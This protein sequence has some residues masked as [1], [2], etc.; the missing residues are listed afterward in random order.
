MKYTIY[1]FSLFLIT[2]SGCEK[3]KSPIKSEIPKNDTS[4]KIVFIMVD[5]VGWG[6]QI[7]RMNIDGSEL[8]QLTFSDEIIDSV[9]ERGYSMSYNPSWSAD[10]TKILY[11]R[12]LGTDTEQAVMMNE[13]GT[14]KHIVTYGSGYTA[15][16][17]WSPADNSFIVG[18]DLDCS[19]S[20]IIFVDTLGNR[21]NIPR[22]ENP[23][24]LGDDSIFYNYDDIDWH[25]NVSQQIAQ[26]IP[27]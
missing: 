13:D 11:K 1:L 21:Y 6:N 4:A 7:Y 10:G 14:D 19:T 24:I 17:M 3:N 16:A 22:P 9:Y 8:K 12:S 18:C 27:I 26:P 2:I 20:T 15:L 25:P 5:E 23:F